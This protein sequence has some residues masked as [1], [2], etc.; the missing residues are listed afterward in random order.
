M[1]KVS[2]AEAREQFS[3]LVNRAAYGKERVVVL[4]RGKEVAALVPIED[5]RLLDA[6]EQRMDL[7][8]ARTALAEAAAQ[9]TVTWEAL[10]SELGL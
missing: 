7:D 1:R 8:E 3:D 4:R 6:I 9:G 5:V 2:T 10:K